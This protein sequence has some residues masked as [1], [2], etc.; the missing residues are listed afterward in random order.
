MNICA[1]CGKPLNKS[2]FSK[3][4]DYKSCPNCSVNNGM[5][6]VFYPY[7]TNFGTTQLRIT[8]KTPDGAQSYCYRCRGGDEGPY[9]DGIL[10]SQI[11]SHV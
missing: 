5:E 6:H 8:P 9:E 4:R 3:N 2:Q 7:P 10:C 11:S 1:S